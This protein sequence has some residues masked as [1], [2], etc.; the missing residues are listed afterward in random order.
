MRLVGFLFPRYA[1]VSFHSSDSYL[2]D[3][4]V[5]GMLDFG[6]NFLTFQAAESNMPDAL[7]R[8]LSCLL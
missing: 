2:P 5:R 6:I 3:Y 7:S 1:A 8:C 4:L